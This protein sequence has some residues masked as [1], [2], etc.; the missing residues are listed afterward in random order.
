MAHT[1]ELEAAVLC[2]NF[3][4]VVHPVFRDV[5]RP[6]EGEAHLPPDGARGEI[7]VPGESSV[8]TTRKM[9]PCEENGY[10]RL[11]GQKCDTRGATMAPG[12]KQS[13]LR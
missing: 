8:S 2:T 12:G 4:S 6:I 11:R 3:A 1:H 7:R 13:T 9:N 5:E 10:L